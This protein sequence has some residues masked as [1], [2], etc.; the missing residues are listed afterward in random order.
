MRRTRIKDLRIRGAVYR[1]LLL[2]P[3]WVLRVRYLMK[4]YLDANLNKFDWVVT[5]R[6]SLP[7][8]GF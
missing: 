2:L 8:S 3:P 4:G 6:S 1:D 7:R 5:V